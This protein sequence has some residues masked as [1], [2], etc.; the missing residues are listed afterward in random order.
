M[1]MSGHRGILEVI[2]FRAAF[3]WTVG[4][5]YFGL[6]LIAAIV[7][8]LFLPVERYDPWLKA[9]LRFLF[10]L[11]GIPVRV[12]G[13]ERVLKKRTYLFMA[14]HVSLFD[15][16]L[17][18]GFVPGIIRGVEA[19]RQSSW[20]L[21]GLAMRRMGNI[22]INRRNVFEAMKSLKRARSRLGQGR[23]LVI[24]P[25]GHRTLDGNLRPFKRLPFH[26]AKEAEVEIMPVGISGLFTLKP[27]HSWLIRPTPLTIAFGPPIP[28]EEVRRLS[29][30]ELRDLTRSRIER[31]IE[32]P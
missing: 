2:R 8:S 3:L 17:L 11:M 6:G 13:A 29:A 15:I 20:P 24:L 7:F 25:E 12:K 19:T 16:P 4:L 14:N 32:R 1:P 5:L 9:L 23:S 21:Y 30:R 28:V 18:G 31:L 22:P 27:K 26:L 10:R